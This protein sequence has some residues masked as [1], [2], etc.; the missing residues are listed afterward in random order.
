MATKL[1]LANESLQSGVNWCDCLVEFRLIGLADA[2]VLKSA[3][4]AGNLEWACRELAETIGRRI[5]QRAARIARLLLPVLAIGIGVPIAIFAVAIILP[6]VQ[7]V[8][9]LSQ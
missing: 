6:L 3:Q 5:R 7:I 4:R 2:A 9:D 8:G 1:A